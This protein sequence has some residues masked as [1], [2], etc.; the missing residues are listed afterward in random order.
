VGTYEL[1][2]MHTYHLNPRPVLLVAGEPISTVGCTTKDADAIT[3][4]VFEAVSAMYYQYSEH[5]TT[6]RNSDPE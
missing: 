6:H 4:R 3:Q 1:L 2:P 5:E